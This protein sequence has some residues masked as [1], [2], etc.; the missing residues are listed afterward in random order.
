M[1]SMRWGYFPQ[2][3]ALAKG[4]RTGSLMIRRP[5]CVP[6]DLTCVTIGLTLGGLHVSRAVF[7][8]GSQGRWIPTTSANPGSCG[9]VGHKHRET[10]SQFSAV[11][12]TK[13]CGRRSSSR[14]AC[15]SSKPC[16]RFLDCVGSLMR[17]AFYALYVFYAWWFY[18]P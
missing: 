18:F 3:G 15:E 7:P 13:V 11:V 17:Y 16:G 10:G 12:G 1:R 14:D 6:H 5:C 9:P 2:L 4:V 8:E